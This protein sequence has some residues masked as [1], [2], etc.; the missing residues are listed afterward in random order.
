MRVLV[1]D[2]WIP[3]PLESGKKIRTFHLLS[4]LSAAT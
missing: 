2:E 3:L 1:T 4:P